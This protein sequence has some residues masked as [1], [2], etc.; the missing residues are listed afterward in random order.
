MQVQLLT[1]VPAVGFAT[2]R[3]SGRLDPGRTS[4]LHWQISSLHHRGSSQCQVRT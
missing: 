3:L 4:Q 2:A 1:R